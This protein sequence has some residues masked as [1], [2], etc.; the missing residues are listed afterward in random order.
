MTGE[1]IKEEKICGTA[2]YVLPHV[3]LQGGDGQMWERYLV[4]VR[5]RSCN[6][7]MVTI[8]SDTV[9]G[10]GALSNKASCSHAFLFFL[11]SSG[12]EEN[13]RTIQKESK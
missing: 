3:L 12:L 7:R 10:K 6:H 5:H 11:C 9:D 4:K 13:G 1:S 8:G 2:P